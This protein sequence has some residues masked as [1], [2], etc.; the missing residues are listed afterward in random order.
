MAYEQLNNSNQRA[1]FWLSQSRFEAEA[2]S[3]VG[4]TRELAL[5]K[6]SSRKGGYMIKSVEAEYFDSKRVS[7]AWSPFERN[8]DELFGNTRAKTV[9]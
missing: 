3:P 1:G 7:A 5:D 8:R 2:T 4:W 6:R 9:D